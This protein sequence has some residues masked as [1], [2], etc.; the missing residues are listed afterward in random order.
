MKTIFHSALLA[1]GAATFLLSALALTS[2]PSP[3]AFPITPDEGCGACQTNSPII[4]PVETKRVSFDVPLTIPEGGLTR[5]LVAY[6]STNGLTWAEVKRVRVPEPTGQR[7]K[8]YLRISGSQMWW[9]I[10]GY[11]NFTQII[12]FDF[13]NTASMGFYFATGTNQ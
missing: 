5:Y 4:N 9:D 7:A 13:T 3:L 1:S 12:H 2:A 8:W 11:T 10:Q 6:Q